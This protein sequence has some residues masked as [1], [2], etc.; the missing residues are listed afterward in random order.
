MSVNAGLECAWCHDKKGPFPVF[1]TIK[2]STHTERGHKCPKC[3]QSFISVQK[4]EQKPY[5]KKEFP[6]EKTNV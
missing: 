5:L 4:S 1:K 2:Y 3:G 6:Q